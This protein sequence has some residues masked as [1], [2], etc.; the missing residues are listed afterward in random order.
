VIFALAEDRKSVKARILSPGERILISGRTIL[1]PGSI[2]QPRDEDSRASYAIF[3]PENNTWTNHRVPYNI[4]AVQARMKKAGLP[5]AH[6]QR[7]ELG[8]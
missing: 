6:I 5:K 1:N 7:L 2:G 3:D 8:W 4:K